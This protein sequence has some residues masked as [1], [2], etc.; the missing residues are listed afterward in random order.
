MTK[1]VQPPAKIKPAELLLRRFKRVEEVMEKC[2][3]E[4]RKLGLP[5]GFMKF[6]VDYNKNVGRR[7][8]YELWLEQVCIPF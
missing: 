2:A 8:K 1:Q 4:N 6:Y 5:E 7:M 3:A